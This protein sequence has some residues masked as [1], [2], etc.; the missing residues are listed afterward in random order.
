MTRSVTVPETGTARAVE[1][2]QPSNATAL[3]VVKNFMFDSRITEYRKF[4]RSPFVELM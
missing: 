1:T 2:S 4:E 3:N